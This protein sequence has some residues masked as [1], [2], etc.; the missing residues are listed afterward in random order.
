MFSQGKFSELTVSKN[1]SPLYPTGSSY[2][3]LC[4]DWRTDLQGGSQPAED[5]MKG[6]P[7][8]RCLQKPLAGCLA[9]LASPLFP[10]ALMA[11]SGEFH[12]IWWICRSSVMSKILKQG[13]GLMS[14]SLVVL[15]KSGSCAGILHL[16]QEG[17][18]T[19]TSNVVAHLIKTTCFLNCRWPIGKCTQCTEKKNSNKIWLL[20]VLFAEIKITQFKIN[21]V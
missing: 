5:G 10:Q 1:A 13:K 16:S 18:G 6:W 20:A 2:W 11:W 14:F 15:S 17:G 9:C 19:R 8:G 21:Y 7:P 3:G 4:G 12:Y